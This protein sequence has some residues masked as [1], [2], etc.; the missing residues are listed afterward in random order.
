MF[1]F[2]VFLIN[3]IQIGA[4]DF[5]KSSDQFTLNVNLCAILLV[6]VP[7]ATSLIMLVCVTGVFYTEYA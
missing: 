2:P 1:E 6:Q 4:S 7:Y 3:E 5:V